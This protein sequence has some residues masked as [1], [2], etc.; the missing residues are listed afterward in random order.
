[1]PGKARPGG[2][3]EPAGLALVFSSIGH[4]YSHLFMLLYPTVVLALEGEFDLSYG[5]LL[6]L[7]L[8]GFVLFGLAA[9]PAGWLGDRWSATG[10]MAV[11]FL[12]TGGASIATGLASSPT[13]IAVGL[14]LIGLFASI[15]HPVG[16]AWLVRGAANRG[17]ALGVNGVFGSLGVGAGA[18]VAGALTDLIDWRAAFLV[19]GLIAIATGLVFLATV[20][21]Q[22]LAAPGD[23]P[24][25]AGGVGRAERLRAFAVLAVN[26]LLAGLIF[27][28]LSVSLPK[29]F[30]ERLGDLLSG[31]TLGVGGLVSV[32]Y[33]ASGA[34]QLLGGHLADR[35][36]L[37]YIYLMA[38]L[39][40]AALLFLVA[41]LDSLPLLLSSGLLVFL[42]VGALPA[43]NSLFAFYAP[44]RWQ[45]T[46]FGAKFVLSLGIGTL[47][48]PLVALIHDLTGG[49]E[50]MFLTLGGFATAIVFST[51]LLPA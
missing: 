36:R 11:F 3:G 14:A 7:S 10:M 27:Q 48:I 37:K 12:G 13:G 9:L 47:G 29:V 33:F 15:Y 32:V 6:S 43:E 35:F 45:A 4:T 46:A 51:L 23:A 49:F 44:A 2:G 39:G 19:P 17:R 31:G 5:E 18:L 28:A 42:N 8:P 26:L 22:R 16:I 30:A 34:A 38:F 50:W 1:M 20:R 41:R 21:R 25:A 40:Q 24:I